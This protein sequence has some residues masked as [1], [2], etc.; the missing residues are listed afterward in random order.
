MRTKRVA[1]V[2]SALLI[3]VLIGSLFFWQRSLRPSSI[4]P[5]EFNRHWKFVKADPNG[6]QSIDFD[7][8]HWSDVSLPHT[9]NDGDTF[10][11]W[12]LSGHRGEQN[13][14][15]GRTWYRKRFS[16]P[17]SL[18][19][20]LFFIEFEG[21]RQVA[22]VY[23]N[24]H[25]LGVAKS[26]FTPFGFNLT[27]Y[28]RLGAQP[29]VL[30]VM[31]DNRFVHDPPEELAKATPAQLDSTWSEHGL[32]ATIAAMAERVNALIPDELDKLQADQIPWNNPHWHPAHGGLYRNVRMYITDPL[33]ISLPLYS[34]LKTTGPYIY[35]SEIS[36]R[37]ATITTEV[38]IE[39]SRATEEAV[40][41]RVEIADDAGVVVLRKSQSGKIAPGASTVLKVAGVIPP[42]KLWEPGNH[43]HLYQVNC[44]LFTRGKE[45]DRR[46]LSYGIRTARWDAGTGLSLNG[47]PLNLRG[48]GQ[49]TTNEWPG[50]GAAL[51]DWLHFYTLQLMQ[52]AGANFVR[53]G[54][55]A[56]GP[57]CILAADRL[58]LI[59]DQPGLDGE[60]DTHGAAWQ[61]RA[62]AFRDVLIYFRNNPSILIWEGGNQTVLRE[63]AA[64]LRGYMDQYDPRGG[65]V[66]AHRRADEAS[67]EFMDIGIGTEGFAEIPRLPTVEG[68]YDREESPRRVWDDFSPPNFGYREAKGQ[69]YQLTSEQFA[70]D[71]A[72]HFCGKIGKPNQIGGANWIFSDT[73]SGGRVGVEVART[74]GE[75]DAVRLPKEAY[76]VCQTMFREDPQVHII[77]HWNYPAG[78]T[79]PV[80]VASNCD[81]V[82]LLVNG[83]PT[84]LGLVG[85]RYIFSFP[86]VTW[87]SGEI[88][89]I[90]YRGGKPVATDSRHTTGAPFGLRLTPIVGPNGLIADGSDVALIDIEVVDKE[91]NRCPT[92]QVR[93]DF[94]LQGPGIWRGGYNS[95]KIKSTSNLFI[96]VECG[97]NRIAVRTT[98][99]PGKITITAKSEGL[100]PGTL[101]L[102]SIPRPADSLGPD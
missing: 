84:A 99:Q 50:L 1:F 85:D 15:S 100:S 97:I 59:T 10:D 42:P 80:F 76:Y 67:A 49:R 62:D 22:E 36:Q 9:F 20:R 101:T 24:G 14:W 94:G 102:E 93:V 83:T 4:K 82:E 88:R 77:G 5:F 16:I 35:A 27:P 72:L 74:S 95:G 96:D 81:K 11:D 63:H 47:H 79:K 61:L 29:N 68:E 78:T 2:A 66:Y 70:V 8:S 26:G 38:P 52:Q 69:T 34:F 19:G 71:E 65:R 87:A 46:A 56:A 64:E 98:N 18:E 6:A 3:G 32:P 51:P 12:S 40:E 39:N 13:Q 37:S 75:V 23:L 45:V 31:C 53:W 73:T 21:A 58:G 28:L 48:W 86:N 25:L 41:V 30:A 92:S 57:V 90:G 89:A 43:P 54:H 7:D 55:C 33:H 91:G 44:L 17:K 60:F